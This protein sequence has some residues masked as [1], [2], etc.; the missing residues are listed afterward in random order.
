MRSDT[1]FLQWPDR[2]FGSKTSGLVVWIGGPARLS[3]GDLGAVVAVAVFVVDDEEDDAQQEADGAH[4]DV[5]DSQERV[6]SSHPGD[7]AQ[8]H[9]LPA[10][11]APHRII[12]DTPVKDFYCQSFLYREAKS[13]PSTSCPRVPYC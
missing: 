8:D 11:E 1:R 9:P 13:R 4:G 7:G 12:W 3:V 10:L 2:M 5:G 6:L